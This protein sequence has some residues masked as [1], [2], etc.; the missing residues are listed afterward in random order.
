MKSSIRSKSAFA[1]RGGV[2]RVAGIVFAARRRIAKSGR[3]AGLAAAT[4]AEACGAALTP[5]AAQADGF[6]FQ[7]FIEP[8]QPPFNGV[9]FTNLLG[10]N[11]KGAIAGFYG[12]GQAG[13]PNTGFLLTPPNT[14]T[15]KNFP[16][17]A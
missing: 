11:N 15:P 5:G 1:R 16:G 2:G 6:N 14:F 10:I 3:A 9:T 13:D 12:S 8:V 17:S 7:T 4:F